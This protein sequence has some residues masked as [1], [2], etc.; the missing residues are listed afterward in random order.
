MVYANELTP[1]CAVSG[2]GPNR[3]RSASQVFAMI[4]SIVHY[5]EVVRVILG[6]F[7]EHVCNVTFEYLSLEL[8]TII[9][10]RS[11][12]C[13]NGN[14]KSFERTASFQIA[15]YLGCIRCDFGNRE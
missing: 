7:H 3:S 8:L 15:L 2:N 14:G 11:E 4:H 9:V 1:P 13:W 6:V 12:D 5:D 10:P